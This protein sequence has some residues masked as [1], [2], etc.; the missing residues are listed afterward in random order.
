[1]ITTL[2]RY[3]GDINIS[4]CGG[5]KGGFLAGELLLL[6]TGENVEKGILGELDDELEEA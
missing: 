3:I 4:T 2:I 5:I 1:M 6:L